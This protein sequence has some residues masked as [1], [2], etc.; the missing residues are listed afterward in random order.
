[1]SALF[2]RPSINGAVGPTLR[3]N[4]L[5]FG[6]VRCN[7]RVQQ[8]RRAQNFVAYEE[9]V[10]RAAEEVDNALIAYHREL[11]RKVALK[12]AVTAF[13]TAVEVSE[14]Q[15]AEGTESFQ[16]VLDSQRSLL[17][18]QDQLAVSEANVIR[19][20]IQNLSG[21]RR[22]LGHALPWT[23]DWRNPTSATGRIRS[24]T[25]TAEPSSGSGNAAADTG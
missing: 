12:G 23:G 1:M 4:F 14:R 3:W 10:Y 15:Y 16:R 25:G 5:N 11:D 2:T 7:I 21:V 6:R 8:A 13:Q 22:R 24:R 17:A 19:N 9:T 20:L 18:F